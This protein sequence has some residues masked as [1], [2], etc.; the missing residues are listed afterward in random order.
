MNQCE[1]KG[2][3]FKYTLLSRRSCFRAGT[4]YYMRGI[5]TEG[6]VANFVETEQI[7]EFSGIKCSF[8]QVSNLMFS[9]FESTVGGY[10]FNFKRQNYA[11]A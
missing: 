5:D 2:Q 6:H 1:L 11:G 8:V 9:N 4:R 10:C 7:I 3:A